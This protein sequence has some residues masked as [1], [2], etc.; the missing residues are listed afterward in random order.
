MRSGLFKLW[1]WWMVVM[2]MKTVNVCT[3]LD[4]W[5]ISKTLPLL[6]LPF[7][8][9]LKSKGRNRGVVTILLWIAAAVC[10]VICC[11]TLFSPSRRENVVCV[12][13]SLI[14][15]DGR[16]EFVWQPS[17]IPNSSE[18]EEAKD[19]IKI[20]VGPTDERINGRVEI[21]FSWRL[22]PSDSRLDSRRFCVFMC[23]NKRNATRERNTISKKCM[24]GRRRN[25]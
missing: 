12:F 9:W 5:A 6:L 23:Y 4:A 1:R 14:A 22:F 10:V 13:Q 17:H 20:L 8:T 24:F 25:E 2:K 16:L 21:N 18:Q 3:M 15:W 7:L 11:I 19:D